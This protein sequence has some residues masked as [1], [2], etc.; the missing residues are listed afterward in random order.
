[1]DESNKVNTTKA[2]QVEIDD[3]YSNFDCSINFGST[4]N[5][6]LKLIICAYVIEGD[7]VTF[8][9]AESGEEVDSTLVT[10]GSFKSVTLNYVAAL[11]TSK[12]EE[13]A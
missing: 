12:E 3:E 8:I 1:F 11:P 9:Q 6:D 2:L 4:A 10:G 13:I 7:N 5:S